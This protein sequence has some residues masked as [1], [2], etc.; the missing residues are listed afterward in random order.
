MASKSA[1][2]SSVRKLTDIIDLLKREKCEFFVD[3]LN[4]PTMHIPDDGFQQDWSVES[5]RVSD[6]LTSLFYFHTHRLLSGSELVFLKTIV[7]E[8]CRKGGR[9]K[10][11]EEEETLERDPIFQGMSHLMNESVSWGGRTAEL[12]KILNSLQESGKITNQLEIT[13]VTNFFV[14]R[15][16]SLI[17]ALRGEGI[18]VNIVHK[19]E[20]SY[21][22]VKRLENFSREP[23][24]GQMIADGNNLSSSAASSG[25]NVCGNNAYREYDDTDAVWTYETSDAKQGASEEKTGE[26]KAP[27]TGKK[28]GK[29]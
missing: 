5:Q 21:T 12:Q 9:R 17:P 28:G 26:K 29:T 4:R 2:G 24:S 23:N 16:K 19:E 3:S 22:T 13:P 11:Q 10:S 20:G 6:Q 27:E 18:E 8:E 15:V 7:R 25:V 14:R 1:T